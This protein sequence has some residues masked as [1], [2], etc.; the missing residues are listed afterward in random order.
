MGKPPVLTPRPSSFF[1]ILF[2]PLLFPPSPILRAPQPG[3]VQDVPQRHDRLHGGIHRAH[4]RDRR[5][6]GTL[7]PPSLLA[8]QCSSRT[9]IG[10]IYPLFAGTTSAAAFSRRLQPPRVVCRVITAANPAA[11]NCPLPPPPPNVA[12]ISPP[13][14]TGSHTLRFQAQ[15]ALSSSI[16]IPHPIFFTF[17]SRRAPLCVSNC[18]HSHT[19]PHSLSHSHSHSPP[20]ALP[21]APLALPTH[22]LLLST[23]SS[24]RPR[25]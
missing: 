18:S 8:L 12:T 13:R 15:P 3:Q 9:H 11:F 7:R 1:F 16:T 22:A 23:V 2:F 21:L 24:K 6:D 10:P 4:R 20:L 19:H 14:T 5:N 17:P 25:R